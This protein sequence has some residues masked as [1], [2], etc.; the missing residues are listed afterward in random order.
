LQAAVEVVTVIVVVTGPVGGRVGG[1]IGIKERCCCNSLTRKKGQ[2]ARKGK[3]HDPAKQ[4][5]KVAGID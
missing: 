4:N 2:T 3:S 5:W 1:L